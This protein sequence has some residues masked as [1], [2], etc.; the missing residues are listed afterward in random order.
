MI[1]IRPF[2]LED[3]EAIRLFTDREIG[4][5]YYSLSEIEDIFHRSQ[6]NGVMCSYLLETPQGDIKGVR[7]SYPPGLWTK[8]KGHG[9]HP[10]QWPHPLE[11]TGYFQ[12]LFLAHDFQ[13]QGWGAKLS[14]E[15]IKALKQ[16][17]SKG[18]V[19]HSWKESPNDSSGRY[20]KKLGFELIAEHPKYWKDVQYNCTRCG[21]PPCQCTA[22]EMYLN[23]ERIL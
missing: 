8:G 16:V 11:A 10:D 23:L 17:G 14:L 18:I 7:I 19:C 3:L 2:R 22:Q 15:A 20:L 1:Q 9:L 13:G 21:A 12:S 5:G 6:R 4:V